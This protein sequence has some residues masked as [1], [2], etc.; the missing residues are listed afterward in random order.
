MTSPVSTKSSPSSFPGSPA[1]ELPATDP[2]VAFILTI[3][4]ALHTSGTPAHR[5]EG[6]LSRC[7]ERLGLTAQFFS[8]PTSLFAAF[9][10]LAEQRTFLIRV[11]P[12]NVDLEQLVALDRVLEEVGAGRAG[13]ADAQQEVQRIVAAPPRYG[14]FAQTIG[15]AV[16][17]GGA[18][19]FFG[20][21]WREMVAATGIG[22]VIG[23]MAALL[24][25]RPRGARVF[26]PLAGFAAALLAFVGAWLLGPMSIRT[27]TVS[28][29]IVLLPGLMLTLSMNELATRNLVSGTARLLG[30]MMVLIG[31]GFGVALGFQVGR[32]LP[33]EEAI[34]TGATLPWWGEIIALASSA[35]AL[36]VLFHARPVDYP[37]V[38]LA[39]AIGLYGAWGGSLLL[40][41]ELGAFAGAFLVALA[42]N[43]DA[44][45]RNRPAAVM[46]LPGII[47]L[48]PGSI[49]F[50]SFESLLDHN[51]LSGVEGAFTMMLVGVSIVA[52]LLLANVAA[53]V[54][55]EL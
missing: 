41:P 47:L 53:P 35:A 27:A 8:T 34:L 21:S 6:A 18:A 42:S 26:E 52:G 17:G 44:R 31:L 39:T 5:L 40:G 55:K 48:V 51:V 24:L 15:F 33:V 36:T 46:L 54:R 14:A 3:G 38:L 49:G 16:I 9:G 12:G 50:R 2:A 30:A 25:H 19:G 7:A 28:G 23:L 1:T 43:L 10:V 29:I 37:A 32:F 4:R 45:I 11:D 13:V 22:L 20:G